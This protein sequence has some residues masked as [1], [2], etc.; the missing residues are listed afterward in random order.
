MQTPFI[1]VRERLRELAAAAAPDD[2]ARV[3]N[4]GSAAGVKIKRLR[5]YSYAASKAAVR[6]M[7]RDL[8]GDLAERN[9]TVNAA[10]PCFFSTRM[11]AHMRDEGSVNPALLAQIPLDG[12]VVGCG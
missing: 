6:M 12:G 8:A 10:I 2:P 1:P 9:M 5:A 3:I 7:T 4:I 11:T